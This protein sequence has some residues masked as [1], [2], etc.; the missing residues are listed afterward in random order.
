MIKKDELLRLLKDA[1]YAEEDG[2]LIYQKHLNNALFWTGVDKDKAK[3]ARRMLDILAKGSI[4]HKPIV[5]GMIDRVKESDK[6]A[7]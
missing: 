5:Q 2:I 3:E 1:Y 6:D 4:A 7:F